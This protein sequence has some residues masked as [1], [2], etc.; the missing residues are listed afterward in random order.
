MNAGE[1]GRDGVPTTPRP[2]Q[3]EIPPLPSERDSAAPHLARGR[4]GTLYGIG[5]G[6]GDPELIT[7]KGLRLLQAAQVVFVPTR[8]EGAA[9]YALELAWPHLD[10]A[11]QQVVS[12]LYPMPRL[13]PPDVE[14]WRFNAR[15]IARQLA[16]G[17]DGAFVTEG[18]PMLY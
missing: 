15:S 12:L 18:D 5:L 13:G 1:H 16:E 2:P 6:P 7:L 3:V 17:A 11:R 10:L 8:A 9:S 4:A 14:Q